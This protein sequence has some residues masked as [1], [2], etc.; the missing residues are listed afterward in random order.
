MPNK[1]YKLLEKIYQFFKNSA[2]TEYDLSDN[3]NESPADTFLL[4]NA[5]LVNKINE[6]GVWSSEDDFTN[7]HEL[8]ETDLQHIV[9]YVIE[10]I[11]A[12]E[13]KTM[14]RTR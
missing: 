11:E 10:N 2:N 14:K 12:D 4:D 7:Y 8:T 3:I 5:K 9:D 1:K 6:N 13:E